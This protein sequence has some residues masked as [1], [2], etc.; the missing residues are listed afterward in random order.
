MEMHG[1]PG[2]FKTCALKQSTN[3]TIER[4]GVV[5][6]GLGDVRPSFGKAVSV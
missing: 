2:S 3:I 1:E 4:Q 5:A 6:L